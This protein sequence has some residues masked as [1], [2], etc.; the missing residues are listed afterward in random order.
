M[1]RMFVF[2]S[3]IL[4][5]ILTGCE[6]EEGPREGPGTTPQQDQP[7]Q[8]QRD[9]QP[10]DQP[11]DPRGDQPQQDPNQQQ[12]DQQNQ[13]QSGQQQPLPE[14]T[15]E[16]GADHRYNPSQVTVQVGQTV[17]WRNNHDEAHTVTCDLEKVENDQ[18]ISLPEGAQ[19][20]DSGDIRAGDTFRMSFSVPGTYRYVCLHHEDHGMAGTIL[21]QPKAETPGQIPERP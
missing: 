5:L 21:V 13:D 7:Q 14:V 15:V 17:I 19:S 18:L 2:A 6:R 4:G 20:F 8:D 3:A 10:Q 16:I 9:Q 1:L 12:Q 11:L